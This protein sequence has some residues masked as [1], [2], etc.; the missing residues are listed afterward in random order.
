I[1]SIIEEFLSDLHPDY[2]NYTDEVNMLCEI[3]NDY[4]NLVSV[5][6]MEEDSDLDGYVISSLLASGK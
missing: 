4:S 1:E 3:I 2:T 6:D 5:F